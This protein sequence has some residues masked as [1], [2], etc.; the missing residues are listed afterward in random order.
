VRARHVVDGDPHLL[1]GAPL[2]RARREPPEAD[3]GALQ[4]GEDADRAPSASA[5]CRTMS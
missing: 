2:D 4:V 5:A 1:A 3:L